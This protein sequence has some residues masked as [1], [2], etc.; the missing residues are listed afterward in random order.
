VRR[1]RIPAATAVYFL[2]VGG[3]AIGPLAAIAGLDGAALTVVVCASLLAVHIGYGAITHTYWACAACF[4]VPL[5]ALLLSSGAPDNDPDVDW[6]L[7]F[8]YGAVVLT[9]CVAGLI[10]V[11]VA[12]GRRFSSPS[13][14]R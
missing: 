4:A 3:L 10:A 8:L 6:S 12:A 2:T 13:S 11:G 5:I 7:A 14:Y 9:P 1:A